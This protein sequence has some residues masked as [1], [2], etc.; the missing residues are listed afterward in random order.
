MNS[1]APF[2]VDEQTQR[3][4][5]LAG[6]FA[7]SVGVL[8]DEIMDFLLKTENRG[9][10]PILLSHAAL[11]GR[12]QCLALTT[13]VE[14][15]GV[16]M[17]IPPGLAKHW[18]DRWKTVY[19]IKADFAGM[20]IPKPPTLFRARFI[21][22]HEKGNS[23][24]L[25]Y[26]ANEK[27]MAGSCTH[28]KFSGGQSLDEAVPKHNF[29]GTFGCWVSDDDEAPFGNLGG[30]NINTRAVRELGRFGLRTT[31]LPVRLV[32]GADVFSENDSKKHLDRQVVTMCAESETADGD[33][34]NVYFN[35]DDGRVY[36]N[37]WNLG[38]ASG[39]MRFRPVVYLPS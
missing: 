2:C 5:T 38:N 27:L 36:V 4:L 37:N 11:L 25:L 29:T 1:K 26:C 14:T 28:W 3:R 13:S 18:E 32:L 34:P 39:R 35:P 21:A 9:Q 19:G 17:P 10:I 15:G 33:V 12:D 22:M 23:S 7:H 16:S 30:I 20:M 31:T 6:M 8:P 24:E